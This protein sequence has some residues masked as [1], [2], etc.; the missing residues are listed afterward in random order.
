MLFK[1]SE[2]TVEMEQILDI[3]NEMYHFKWTN[4]SQGVIADKFAAN[5][6]TYFNLILTQTKSNKWDL[7]ANQV[8]SLKSSNL[9]PLQLLTQIILLVSRKSPA[10]ISYA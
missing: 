4:G 5:Y 7:V 9:G 6:Y 8:Q 1:F 3:V 10:G 2:N